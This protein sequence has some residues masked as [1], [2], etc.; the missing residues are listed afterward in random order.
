MY[1]ERR[2]NYRIHLENQ[3]NEWKLRY[4]NLAKLYSQQS[5]DCSQLKAQIEQV[6]L[7]LAAFQSSLSQLCISA[8]E[9]PMDSN[10]LGLEQ[11]SLS[12]SALQLDFIKQES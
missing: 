11:D 3:V 10:T 6:S 5:A 8:A 9:L 4:Q 12:E 1:R 7:G 2:E